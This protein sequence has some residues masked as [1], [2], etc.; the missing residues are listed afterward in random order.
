MSSVILSQLQLLMHQNKHLKGLLKTKQAL[1]EKKKN[2]LSSLE[3]EKLNINRTLELQLTLKDQLVSMATMHSSSIKV[4]KIHRYIAKTQNIINALEK[5][6]EQLAHRTSTCKALAKS[7]TF[8]ISLQAITPSHQIQ[9]SN[10]LVKQE[11]LLKSYL[12]DES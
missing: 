2:Q 10:Q 1:L 8:A 12:Q 6:I 4:Q 11:L 5:Q 3:M 7:V 9:L